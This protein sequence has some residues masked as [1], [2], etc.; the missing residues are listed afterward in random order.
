MI[1]C[2]DRIVCRG[3]GDRMIHQS[4]RQAHE[5]S[6]RFGQ[7]IHDEFGRTFYA[8]DIDLVVFK[9]QTRILRVL[10]HKP[11]GGSLSEGQKR[12]LS[13]AAIAVKVLALTRMIDS[14]SGVFVVWA[15]MWSDASM[16]S[17]PK[18]ID[19]KE[20]DGHFSARLEGEEMAKF[21][22]GEHLIDLFG[23]TA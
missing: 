11:T 15:D 21:L 18:F 17:W 19:V 20:H 1:R 22:S 2:D 6:S 13:L 9:K 8:A 3:C 7:W 23:M 14:E 12:I 16:E 5:S 10:E 4:N